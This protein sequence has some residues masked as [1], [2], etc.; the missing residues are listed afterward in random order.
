M[1]IKTVKPI[2]F[3]FFRTIT[4]LSEL[5][6]FFHVASELFKEASVRNLTITGPIHWHYQG[7]EGGD[8]KPF[9]LEI[10]LPISETPQDYDGQ[11]HFKRTEPFKCV[12]AVH[13]GNW[14]DMTGTYN[15]IMVF[16]ASQRLKPSGLNRELYINV[17]FQD[18]SANVTAVQVGI[19]AA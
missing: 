12:S 5:N 4:K 19:N 1:H 9:A 14:M 3:L 11:F 2:N 17:D 16:L 10:A 6:K 8:D 7:F 18:P 15:E 13:E